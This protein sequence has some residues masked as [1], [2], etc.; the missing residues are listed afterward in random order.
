MRHALAATLLP[1]LTLLVVYLAVPG[2]TLFWGDNA[3]Y[4]HPLIRAGQERLWSGDIPFWQRETLLGAPLLAEGQPGVLYLPYSLGWMLARPPLVAKPEHLLEV[5]TLL[6]AALGGLG[7]YLLGLA[8][9]R[10]PWAAL[11]GACAFSINGFWQVCSKSWIV[12]NSLQTWLPLLC[13]AALRVAQTE[14]AD[15]RRIALAAVLWAAQAYG[16]YPQYALL[17]GGMMG[18]TILL[19]AASERKWLK[20][21]RFFAIIIPAG[22]MAAPLWL[23][24]RD[25]AELS[26]RA[27]GLLSNKDAL[28]LSMPPERLMG[29]L[30][31]HWDSTTRYRAVYCFVGAPVVILAALGLIAGARRRPMW[32]LLAAAS[33][34][35]GIPLTLGEYIPG[36]EWM[37]ALPVMNLFRWPF[38]NTYILMFGGSLAAAG[39]VA[40]LMAARPAARNRAAGALTAAALILAAIAWATGPAEKNA[41]LMRWVW[42]MSA[43]GCGAAWALLGRGRHRRRAAAGT[44]TLATLLSLGMAGAS[45]R[46]YG[47]FHQINVEPDPYVANL[48]GPHRTYIA[49]THWKDDPDA[50]T[51]EPEA[52]FVPPAAWRGYSMAA[53]GGAPGV[54]GYSPLLPRRYG[55]FMGADMFSFIRPSARELHA[56][57]IR[58]GHFLDM[59]GVGV[60]FT[61]RFDKEINEAFRQAGW[62]LHQD[63]DWILAWENADPMPRAYFAERVV[64]LANDEKALE[65][66]RNAGKRLRDTAFIAAALAPGQTIQGGKGEILKYEELPDATRIE[67]QT[68]GPAYLVIAESYFPGWSAR[69]DGQP[70]FVDPANYAL[71]GVEIPAGGHHV[72]ELNYMPPSYPIGCSLAGL[73]ALGL[74]LGAI[75]TRRRDREQVVQASVIAAEPTDSPA[76]PSA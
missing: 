41:E 35:W 40:W 45:L 21:G 68:P 47:V 37:F 7:M 76:E 67:C 56:R 64:N 53:L 63:I 70:A 55:E 25:Y 30:F 19:V 38:K 36:A 27:E 1:P 28:K 16:G 58:E 5:I 50:T 46:D 29:A 57:L 65:A 44:L 61:H 26:I 43:I 62:K 12:M 73:A 22:M 71:M 20:M 6:H 48:Q 18:L 74:T 17:N 2:Y 39:G 14:R 3:V 72:I 8:L 13:W 4:F 54:N 34:L 32:W 60:A 49:A 31:P 59:L 52:T 23:P 42:P 11:L 51:Q 15:G 9:L 33:I 66:V 75:A 10:H 69:V 24:M